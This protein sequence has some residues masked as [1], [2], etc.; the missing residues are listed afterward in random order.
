ML[1]LV[2]HWYGAA[3]CSARHARASLEKGIFP[4]DKCPA[5]LAHPHCLCHLAPVYEVE[6]DAS[7]S[8]DRVKRG[9]DEW[10]KSLSYGQRC[11]VLGVSGAKAWEQGHGDWRQYMRG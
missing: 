3:L 5:I 10:L 2:T 1:L 4:K 9:G 6:V 11:T 7:D 8:H